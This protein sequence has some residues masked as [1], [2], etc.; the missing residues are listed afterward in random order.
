M[1]TE[2]TQ[3]NYQG[4]NLNINYYHDP[5]CAATLESPSDPSEFYLEE[6]FINEVD[7]LPWLSESFIEE[8]TNHSEQYLIDKAQEYEMEYQLSKIEDRELAA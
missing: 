6:V 3:L 8:L 7:I 5:G 1:S 4:I 2:N